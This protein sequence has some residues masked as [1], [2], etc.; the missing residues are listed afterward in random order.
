MY[1]N[2]HEQPELSVYSRVANIADPA[3]ARGRTTQHLL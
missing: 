3:M 1:S 2:R